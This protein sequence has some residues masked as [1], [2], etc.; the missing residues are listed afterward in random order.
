MNLLSFYK[1]EGL[2][3]EFSD[4]HMPEI[5]LTLAAGNMVGVYARLNYKCKDIGLFL[6]E[7]SSNSEWRY[8]IDFS[9]QTSVINL[10]S[11]NSEENPTKGLYIMR[12]GDASATF[13]NHNTGSS[14]SNRILLSTTDEIYE[15]GYVFLFTIGFVANENLAKNK[16]LFC[17]ISSYGVLVE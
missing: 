13:F 15:E 4:K 16:R 11:M 12:L 6:T 7:S 14:Y 2:T 3:E 1:D 17:G 5:A 8:P 10:K 9:N